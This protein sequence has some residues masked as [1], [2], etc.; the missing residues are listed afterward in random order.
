[1][2]TH[3]NFQQEVHIQI[4]EKRFQVSYS[5]FLQTVGNVIKTNPKKNIY[6]S[7]AYRLEKF[8]VFFFF[9]LAAE[10][11]FSSKVVQ[12]VEGSRKLES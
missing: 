11:Y 8:R 3:K 7:V 12:G 4:R 10:K 2:R 9:F 6:I 1:M 5:F